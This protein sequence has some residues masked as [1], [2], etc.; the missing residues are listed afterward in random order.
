MTSVIG[1]WPS[2]T[3]AGS[4]IAAAGRRRSG[5][6][7]GA[8]RVRRAWRGGSALLYCTQGRL[9]RR[10]VNTRHPGGTREELQVLPQRGGKC[11]LAEALR[12]GRL[13]RLER[14]LDPGF[15]RQDLD[16]MQ[17][18]AA[19]HQ[20]AAARRSRACRRSRRPV[21][22]RTR[23]W[24][25]SQVAAFGPAGQLEVDLAAVAH[26]DPRCRASRSARPA[27][28]PRRAA[29]GHSPSTPCVTANRM[30]RISTRSPTVVATPPGPRGGGA[31]L[32]SVGSA[33]GVLGPA[34]RS[35][36]A[37]GR[38]GHCTSQRRRI[39]LGQQPGADGSLPKQFGASALAQG[40]GPS[41]A[42]LNRPAP[43]PL[44]CARPE[45]EASMAYSCVDGPHAQPRRGAAGSAGRTLS[46]RERTI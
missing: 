41:T 17:P 39:V 28:K 30:W 21:R 22:A 42:R 44:T 18:E 27:G 46:R 5:S 11:L 40:L 7:A 38:F 16:D 10:Q 4:A 14:R 26:S 37:P 43:R 13:H 1:C 12:H 8:A 3:N 33:G 23:G 34:G 2:S 36:A 35:M 20:P 31:G 25:T 32:L 6:A 29:E 19:V 15:A 45:T 9:G 24:S